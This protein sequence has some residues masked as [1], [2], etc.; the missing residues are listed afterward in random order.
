VR[1]RERE[2]ERREKEKGVT[3]RNEERVR[4]EEGK[5]K[6]G[7]RGNEGGGGALS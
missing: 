2:D 7:D 4:N 3:G 5:I 1:R 6:K